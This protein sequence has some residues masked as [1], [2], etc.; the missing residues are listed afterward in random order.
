MRGV[1]GALV[2][3]RLLHVVDPGVRRLPEP[4]RPL[5]LVLP[6]VHHPV[7]VAC[8]DPAVVAVTGWSRLESETQTQITWGRCDF[9]DC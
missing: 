8:P 4:H 6:E 2:W 3:P 1:V 7:R 9:R 5:V